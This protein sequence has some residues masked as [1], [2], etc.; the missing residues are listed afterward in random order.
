LQS[1][2]RWLD[3][4]LARRIAVLVTGLLLV[5]G[6][7]V[8]VVSYL[9]VLRTTR[10][11]MSDRLQE[12]GA[13][14]APLMGRNSA[15]TMNRLSRTA[16]DSGV[17]GFVVSGGRE[18]GPA[19][20]AVL[21]AALLNNTPQAAV[22]VVDSGGRSLLDLGP[23]RRGAWFGEPPAAV[24]TA[25]SAPHVG[26][27]ARLNDTSLVFDLRIPIRRNGR[28]FGLLVQRGRLTISETARST[29]AVLLGE[30]TGIVLGSPASGIWT[31][32][33][34]VVPPPPEEA[35]QMSSVT[36]IAWRGQRYL[37]S[38]AFVPGTPW[39]LIVRTPWAAVI[40]PADRYLRRAALIA[41][42]V[43]LLGSVG[44]VLIGRTLGKPIR[45]ITEVAEQIVSGDEDRRAE[46]RTPG[47]V[48]RLARAFN[49]MVD[50]VG[51]STRRLRDNETSH[52]AF[53]ALASEGIWRVEFV[54]ALS[55]SLA[56]RVQIDAW[57]QTVP[58]AE[59]N[60]A[61]ALMHGGDGAG[62]TGTIPLERLFPR[63]DPT[64]RALLLDFIANGYRLTAAESRGHDEGGAPRIYVN[65]LI[66]IVENGA[67]R[68]IWGT[69]SDVTVDRLL[70]QR[71]AQTQRLE[72][73][74]RLAGGVAHD[75]NNLLTAMLGYSSSL[76][77]RFSD[78]AGAR[79]DVGEIERLALRASELTR[80][81][82][83]FSRGQ[84]LRPAA[85]DL[86]EVLRGT[87]AMLRR[88]I[89]EDVELKFSLADRL[90]L[91]LGDAGQIE[92][93]VMNLVVNA[94]DAMPAGGVLE[95]RTANVELD[96]EHTIRPG[97]PP[98][99]YVQLAVS[100]SGVGMT[101]EVRLHAFEPFF[102]TKP[103]GRGTGLGLA[104]VYG[105]VRQSGG[106]ITL[107]SEPG[108]GTTFKI[109]LPVRER[110]ADR[111]KAASRAPL[112][113]PSGNETVLLVED[114]APVRDIVRRALTA[115]GY[116]VLDATDGADAL[117]QWES[118]G[119]A[120]DLVLTDMV[121]PGMTGRD[122]AAELLSRRPGLRLIIMSGYTGETYPALE[123]L[124]D[125]VGYLE[126]PFSL[127]DLRQRLRDALDAQG[128]V[129]AAAGPAA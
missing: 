76:L 21:R 87:E 11:L 55:T 61:L 65:G 126:K 53:V 10:K 30:G 112:S 95:I 120:I 85:L 66:G 56:P 74:G 129:A 68:R 103:K 107:Y 34:S 90:D 102:T 97:V 127:A 42:L 27:F 22:A 98:G 50:R 3:H 125:G 20:S 72:A 79:E 69:R 104:T 111:V 18:G 47:E 46:E 75:F 89:G 35:L 91:I 37:S 38:A 100:D 128:D 119:P 114:E 59:C 45:E 77:E 39:L 16:A 67:L 121:L 17:V 70:D 80:Q 36:R 122:L 25:D 5:V 23:P 110:V 48:G 26:T 51:T 86:N 64:S 115:V 81:L 82:L 116:R 4:S 31:D 15:E 9:E 106:E 113:G 123:L 13:Q 32:M 8:S 92:R 101:E 28:P 96:P 78:D 49:A 63:D 88:V 108:R 124:P 109:Y 29:F 117:R 33:A 41:G 83:S 6:L 19:V 118:H 99:H 7:G 24:G 1:L 2:K 57:Y 94:R 44:A 93:V 58:F 40:A 12:L 105:I 60:P 84:V 52:R 54:P 14:L 43:V 73:I 62:E 71:L